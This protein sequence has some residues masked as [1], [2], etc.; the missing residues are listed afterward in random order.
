M[1]YRSLLLALGLALTWISLACIVPDPGHRR[2]PEPDRGH[3]RERDHEREREPER[4]RP[5]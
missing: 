5:H 1:K 3:E 4:E 2:G